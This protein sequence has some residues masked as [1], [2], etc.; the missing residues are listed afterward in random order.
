MS[1]HFVFIATTIIFWLLL[2]AGPSCRKLDLTSDSEMQNPDLGKDGVTHP[3]WEKHILK[4]FSSNQ[5]LPGTAI[6]VLY[7]HFRFFQRSLVFF[8]LQKRLSLR[9]SKWIDHS[10]TLRKCWSQD[11]TIWVWCQSPWNTIPAVGTRWA[12]PTSPCLLMRLTWAKWAGKG[13]RV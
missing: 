1:A 11:C 2:G 12:L 5:Q 7:T 9:E 13:L 6:H 10:H 3:W 4:R 8:I